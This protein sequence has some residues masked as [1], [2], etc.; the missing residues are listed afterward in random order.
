MQNDEETGRMHASVPAAVTASMERFVEHLLHDSV[1]ALTASGPTKTIQ[2]QHMCVCTRMRTTVIC[3]KLA[4]QCSPSLRF[5]VPLFEN[6]ADVKNSKKIIDVLHPAKNTLG[7]NASPTPATQEQP[8]R[9]MHKRRRADV[10]SVTTDCARIQE[11]AGLAQ[12][13]RA[14]VD[15]KRGRNEQLI[16]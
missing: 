5:L 9:A 16:T 15:N 4:V 8:A 10:V 14:S 3:S 6:V 7:T 1:R 2:P 12:H 11:C 13:E